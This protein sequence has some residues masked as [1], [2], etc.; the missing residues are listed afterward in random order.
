MTG[1]VRGSLHKL[2]GR[3]EAQQRELGVCARLVEGEAAAR[4]E[5]RPLLLYVSILPTP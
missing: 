2:L 4:K 1:Q 3:L 5:V